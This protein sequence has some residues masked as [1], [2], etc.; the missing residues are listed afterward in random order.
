MENLAQVGSRVEKYVVNRLRRLGKMLCSV[1]VDPRHARGTRH[2]FASCVLAL[3]CGMVTGRK[4]LRDVESL[5]S[6]LGLGDRG[7]G[8]SDGALS[9]LL[10]LCDEHTFDATLVG[11]VK[12][13]KRRGEL[14][15]PG[16]D[17]AW[18]SIDGKYS[19]LRHDC[20]GLGQKFLTDDSVYWRVGVLRAVVISAPSRPAL[21]Q[22][23]MG[24]A[25]SK[26]PSPDQAKHTGEITNLPLFIA[27]LRADYG[28]LVSNLVL[29][30]GLWSKELFLQLDSAGYG[31]VCG[32]KANKPELHAEVERIF[33][34]MSRRGLSADAQTPCESYRNGW[35]ERKLW[36]SKVLD[37]YN[38]WHN[39]RQVVKV[40]QT[41][42][43]RGPDGKRTGKQ[44]TEVR[45]F[46]SNAT[47][48][49]LSPRQMLQVIRQHWSIENDC[50]WTFDMQFGE[51]QGA[52]CARNKALLVLGVL[53]MIAYNIL[54]HLR[55]SHV[56]TNGAAT[57]PS[58]R[59][60]RT[61]QTK[62]RPW[63]QL[64]ELTCNVLCSGGHA[65]SDRLLGGLHPL[66]KPEPR[67]MRLLM[68]G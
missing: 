48:G 31:V 38:G 68:T 43:E 16:L 49:M 39:L 4:S 45:Y 34:N 60:P 29:D 3:V 53:R 22:W 9:H 66:N 2:D 50:N 6:E 46:I 32:L 67:T 5:S 21:G 37:G 24:P 65:L 62:P 11:M 12:D 51:D 15:H 10:A 36:R 23:A 58:G 44:T 28:D 30:A 27:K 61:L 17:R 7:H 25:P 47:T 14:T 63:R 35:I 26:D 64:F 13:L 40:E 19:S 56:V 42:Y 57:A 1:A 18:T 52:W 41:T 54:Q 20:G 59:T 33:R 55:K 8:V